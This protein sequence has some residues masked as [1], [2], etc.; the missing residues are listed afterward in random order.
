MQCKNR[1]TCTQD[2]FKYKDIAVDY[3]GKGVSVE[4]NSIATSLKH[5]CLLGLNVTSLNS[6]N[7]S[8]VS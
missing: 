2:F 8:A 1:H 7:S 3:P 4:L 6:I 5:L